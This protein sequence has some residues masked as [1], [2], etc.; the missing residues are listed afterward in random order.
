MLR[1]SVR[2]F[3]ELGERERQAENACRFAR[4]LVAAGSPAIA[5]RLLASA[6]ALQEEIGAGR[7]QWLVEMNERTLRAIRA[8]LDDAAF[9]EAWEQ[10]RALTV[11]E[12]VALAADSLD[13]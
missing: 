3:R 5:A 13:A 6:E 7:G 9:T 10:G 8:E 11:D 12:A 4:A 2:L 1:Q